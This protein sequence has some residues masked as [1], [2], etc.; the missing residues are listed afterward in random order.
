MTLT[1]LDPRTG[2]RVTIS[3]PDRPPVRQ[4]APAAVIAHPRLSGR[5]SA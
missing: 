4:P 1:V 2:H 5:R 3:V